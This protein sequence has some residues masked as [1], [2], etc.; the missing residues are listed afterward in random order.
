LLSNTSSASAASGCIAGPNP[1]LAAAPP[2]HD[3]VP[4]YFRMKVGDLE[5]TS[6]F[7]GAAVIGLD[8]LTASKATIERVATELH[9]D[10]H[11][12]DAT[13]QWTER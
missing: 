8:W 10:P 7:D 5:V 1:V 11:L 3:Q 9:Q 2:H 12:L 13:Q 6:L 4:G